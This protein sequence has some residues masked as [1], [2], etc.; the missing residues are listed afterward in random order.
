MALISSRERELQAGPEQHG[1]LLSVRGEWTRIAS[2]ARA[3]LGELAPLWVGGL[4]LL[5]L[6]A[7]HL[8]FHQ[9]LGL[10]P[11]S[12]DWAQYLLIGTFFPALI[13]GAV[14]LPRRWAASAV[15]RA[16]QAVLVLVLLL[17]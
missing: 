14:L 2:A 9:G 15:A 7:G 16:A 4:M 10:S 1:W 17:A 12:Y 3:E 5:C 6:L 11:K 8:L 13:L